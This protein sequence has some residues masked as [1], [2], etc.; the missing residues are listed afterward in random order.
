MYIQY[1]DFL[2]AYYYSQNFN[3]LEKLFDAKLSLILICFLYHFQMSIIS[4]YFNFYKFYKDN[5]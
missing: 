5:W 4:V 2:T 1:L 3:K